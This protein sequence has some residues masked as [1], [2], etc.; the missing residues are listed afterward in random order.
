MENLSLLGVVRR[1]EPFLGLIEHHHYGP[2]GFEQVGDVRGAV[3]GGE[4]VE[5]TFALVEVFLV[6][7]NVADA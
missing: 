5:K 2:C 3:E 4:L 6:A 1:N 7:D